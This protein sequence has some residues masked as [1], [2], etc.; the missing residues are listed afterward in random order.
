M[1][2][3]KAILAKDYKEYV[4]FTC[5]ETKWEWAAHKV[6]N[7]CTYDGYLDELFVKKIIEV[8]KA[9]LD[10]KTFEY[11]AVDETQHYIDYIVICQWLNQLGWIEW[12]TSIRGAWFDGH[13]HGGEQAKLV[14]Y[15]YTDFDAPIGVP[16]TE[17]N[18]RAFID[19]M[20][21]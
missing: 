19:F 3:I 5:G 2:N 9:I 1:T 6:F 13:G 4:E 8:C 7:L 16:F 15:L 12:G 21:E 10:R 20:E 11:M 17:D 14:Q 18:L